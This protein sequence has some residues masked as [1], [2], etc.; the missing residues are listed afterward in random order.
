MIRCIVFDFDGTLVVSNHIKLQ[1]FYEVTYSHDPTGSTVTRIL[2][3]YPAKDRH[4]VF[5][6]IVH[7][8]VVKNQIP[9][10]QSPEALATQWAEDYTFSCEQAI[11]TCEEVP[12]TTETLRWISQQNIPIFINSRTPTPT[13]NRLVT[14]RSFDRYT[15]KIYGAPATKTEN[16]WLIQNLA[17][18]RFQEILFV[19]DSEDDR[20]AALE[21]GCHFVGVILGEQNRFS[22]PP[23]EIQ[24]SDLYQL[25]PIVRTLQDKDTQIVNK[26]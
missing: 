20:K 7:E 2:E 5:L 9:K 3:Q 1:T 6:E 15:S 21:V 8:L 23:P 12:G 11:A 14:L 24:I 13:L 18:A 22:H 4:G 19:G 17:Q 10:H 25:Q 26:Y 16:L